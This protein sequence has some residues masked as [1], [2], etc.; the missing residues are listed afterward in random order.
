MHGIESNA[1]LFD[2]PATSLLCASARPSRRFRVSSGAPSLPLLPLLLLLHAMAAQADCIWQNGAST[3]T[4]TFAIPPIAVPR[5]VAV[6]TVLYT[7]PRQRGLPISGNYAYCASGG[8][9]YYAV[10]GAVQVTSSPPTF[11]TSVPGIGI[12][13]FRS[14]GPTGGPRYFGPTSKETWNSYWTFQNNGGQYFGIE[15]VATGQVGAGTIDPSVSGVY[16]LGSLTIANLLI[17]SAQVVAQTC[18]INADPAVNLPEVSVSAFP[19]IGSTAGRTPF[20]I[21][22]TNCPAQMRA[23]QYQLDSPGGVLDAAAGTF[24]VGSASTTQGVGLMVT[25]SAD[26]TFSLGSMHTLTQYNPSTGGTYAL[27]FNLRYYRT[28]TI[29]PGAVRAQITYTISYQ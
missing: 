5:D 19:T 26:S 18:D 16:T 24:A 21:T 27:D 6:G 4:Y 10:M 7:P 29:S 13:I 8:N 22:L 2:T 11:A 9:A 15:L 17:T 25:D 20:R 12:R 14:D 23:I 1:R 3:V 28:G